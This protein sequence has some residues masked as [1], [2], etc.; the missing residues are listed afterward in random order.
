MVRFDVDHSFNLGEELEVNISNAVVEEF[1][2]LLQVAGG[3]LANG[4]VISVGNSITPRVATVQDILNNHSSWESTLV[5]VQNATLSGGSTYGDFGVMINDPSGSMSMFS[6]FANFGGT[7][8][9]SGTGDV[10]AVVGEFSNPNYTPQLNIRNLTDVNGFSGSGGGG[11]NTIMSIADVRALYM[12][13]N[14]T[15]PANRSIAGIVISDKD[16]ENITGRNLIMQQTGGSGIV[17]RFDANNTTI[18][19]G[20]SIVVDISGGTVSEFNGLRQID[21][22]PNAN[23]TIVSNNN[24]ITPRV[25]TVQDIL[26]NYN[27]WESTLVR[28]NG[29]TITG[30][31]TY[32]FGTTV[33]DGTGNIDMFTRSQA[34]FSGNAVP[35]GSVNI[36]AVVSEF[37]SPQVVIRN[38]SD[39]Q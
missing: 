19:L 23:A 36:T 25:A 12:G 10:T 29:A 24:S 5:N 34:T 26:T 17:V 33:S 3:S 18:A 31:A 1:N 35:S 2:G 16:A 8:L 30:S 37:N 13:S 15:V 7:A 38:A 27:A 4:N 21:N 28:I 39:V 20:D 6:G 22:V 32:A 9:P 11:T 14:A